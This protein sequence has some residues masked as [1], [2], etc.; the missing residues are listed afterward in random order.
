[1]LSEL[2][3]YSS[4]MAKV[5]LKY[6]RK[7]RFVKHRVFRNSSRSGNQWKYSDHIECSHALEKTVI[8]FFLTFIFCVKLPLITGMCIQ[9]IRSVQLSVCYFCGGLF[10]FITSS[11]AQPR[12][13]QALR[14][15]DDQSVQ[16]NG[17]L[18]E[19]FWEDAQPATAFLQQ[20]PKEGLPA[21]EDTQVF[22]VFDR[23]YLYIGAALLDSDPDGVV[24]FQK[25]RDASLQSDD[26]FMWIL[27][28]FNDGRTGYFFEINP[29]GLMGDGLLGTV[30]GVNKSWDGIW[31]ARVDKG[32]HGWSAEIRI[33]FRT[34]NFDPAN[35]TWGINFQRTIR[36]KNE[37]T[38]WS[39]HRRNQSLFEPVFAGD[40]TGLEGMS[41]GT[42]LEVKP[43]AVTNWSHIPTREDA[44]SYNA[45]A[46][47]DLTYSLTS[48]LRGAVSIN[49][50][51][52]EVE[53]DQRRVNL[54]RFPLFFPEKRDFFL[55][56]S[57]VFNFAPRNG[58]NPYFSRRIGLSGGR[59][60]P[61]MYGARLAGQEGPFDIGF[62]H[63]RTRSNSALPGENFTVGRVKRNFGEQSS[64]GM[65]FTR[66]A[67]GEFDDAA[68]APDR[69]TLGTDLE[70]TTRRFLGTDKNFN[71]QAF[72]VWHTENTFEESST[73][74][75][76]S[77][78]GLRFRYANEPWTVQTSYRE[79]GAFYNPALGFVSRN[80]YKRI[81]PQG[82]FEP[83]LTNSPIIRDLNFRVAVE[84]IWSLQN[85]V[86][87]RGIEA[88]FLGIEFESG[89]EIAFG[90]EFA[91]EVLENNFNIYEDLVIDAGD[92]RFTTW[93]FEAET[94]S[95]RNVAGFV[96]AT[97][98]KFWS[99]TR[100]SYD[101]GVIVKPI[102]G[103]S[104]TSSWE[105][106]R[107]NL[108]EG[109]F[110]TNLYRFSGGWQ[111]SPWTSLTTILQYDDVS[112]LLTLFTRFRWTIRPGNDVFLIFNRNWENEFATVNPDRFMLRAFET[113]AAVKVNYTHR[114]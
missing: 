68:F 113:G 61:I 78:R 31:E 28:T 64:I 84:S 83:R 2:Q 59:P 96:E 35:D 18:D 109:N 46:G 17:R 33:P 97:A 47:F 90:F 99:G 32:A 4:K 85:E 62:L 37:E 73:D 72:W 7:K 71:F 8:L 20:E 60:V 45:D 44:T 110:T 82:S 15:E 11:F 105:Q 81:E 80:G 51:F 104:L 43:Y 75:D 25:Q 112:E 89:D 30:F 40:L 14:L 74:L 91:D 65:M 12:Q 108:D 63:V 76:R 95:R 103:L 38:L 3:V 57:S 24:G 106:N 86:L 94:A 9:Y 27:D 107:V 29:A 50:D 22:I 13:L 100:T 102:P 52:A 5:K 41:Q 77:V 92:Y 58:A 36:R 56:G 19:P 21:T 93:G 67:S 1:M 66:R 49:T 54:T 114:W 48:S 26:R 69:Y 10:L 16:L 87:T 34:L 53:V 70:L 111:V 23:Q 42:G 101:A 6:H 79:F 39:G 55:E 98:G 88:T